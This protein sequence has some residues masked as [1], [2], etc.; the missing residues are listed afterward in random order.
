LLSTWL[1]GSPDARIRLLGVGGSNLSPAD[2]R[3]LFADDV[4][5]ATRGI[6]Q[7][8][9]EIQ[10]RFGTASVRRARTLHRP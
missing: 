8:V 7:A 10:D 4:G 9:D 6:D 1:D 3:D 2:Q 5:G